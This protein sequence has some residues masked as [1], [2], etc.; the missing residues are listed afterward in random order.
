MTDVNA[1]SITANQITANQVQANSFGGVGGQGAVLYADKIVLGG[2]WEIR[3]GDNGIYVKTPGGFETK[4]ELIDYRE[5]PVPETAALELAPSRAAVS[6]E[7]PGGPQTNPRDTGTGSWSGGG[8][9]QNATAGSPGEPVSTT[10]ANRITP[11]GDGVGYQPISDAARARLPEN[12]RNDARFMECLDNLAKEKNVPADSILAIMQIESGLGTNY[13][14]GGRNGV[15]ALNPG[16]Q[17][18]GLIQI[19]PSTARGLGYST[20]QILQMSPGE[21]MCGPVTQYYRSVRLP[22]NPTTGDLYLSTFYPAAVGKPDDYVIGNHPNLSP[23]AVARANPILRG[24]DGLVT[25]GSVRQY[26]A[27]R[28]S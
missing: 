8:G 17:A 4:V 1:D 21:Q 12:Y 5:T 14:P 16:T 27:S 28:S 13:A 23:Q 22:A 9:I 3:A 11:G 24:P 20:E 6:I 7:L 26:I 25:V 10:P 19:M 15:T 18:A 2:N